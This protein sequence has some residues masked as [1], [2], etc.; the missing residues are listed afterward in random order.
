[1]IKWPN[2][3]VFT[4]VMFSGLYGF[5][6]VPQ[7]KALTLIW[8]F[9]CAFGGALGVTAG[10]HRLW[11]HRA[12]KARLPLK[13][14]LAI[15]NT[16][17]LQ[18]SILSWSINHRAHHKYSE[19]D[20]DPHNSKR[21]FFFSHVGWFLIKE[22]PAVLEKRKTIDASDLLNDEVVMFQYRLSSISVFIVL[23]FFYSSAVPT[24]LWGESFSY[25]FFLC[26]ARFFHQMNCMSMV[27]SVAHLWGKR[28]FEKD[29]GPA[30][31]PLT[32]FLTIGEGYHNFHH[33]F[34]HDYRASESGVYFNPSTV[35]I[36]LMA[37]LGLAYDLRVMSKQVL[38][39]RRLR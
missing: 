29:I 16:L 20:A 8:V 9:V 39:R 27:N 1:R 18:T 19:T 37:K 24:L 31:N 25:S 22:H 10:V 30:D 13:I 38:E 21:G 23:H 4:V 33:V 26:M 17:S 35:F 32:A 3:I 34:P 15:L 12:Y 2:L 28:P 11:T 7:V 14:F 5:T 6:L 36:D